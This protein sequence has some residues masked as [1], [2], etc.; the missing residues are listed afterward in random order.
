[1]Y[2]ILNRAL[3]YNGPPTTQLHPLSLHD[4]LPILMEGQREALVLKHQ[5]VMPRD[6]GRELAACPIE[7]LG[8]HRVTGDPS[9]GVASLDAVLTR[10]REPVVPHQ[11]VD[12]RDRATADH[13]DRA[14][15]RAT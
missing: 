3:I 6:R 10:H 15:A 13:G 14:P 8:R 4:A 1:D 5:P 7:P 9:G 2:L 12:V 11:S